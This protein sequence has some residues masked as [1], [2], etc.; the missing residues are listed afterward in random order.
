M[1]PYRGEKN[2]ENVLDEFQG[3]GKYSH[4]VKTLTGADKGSRKNNFP[5]L[6]AE[7]PVWQ[8]ARTA[9]TPL[10]GK[11]EQRRQTGWIDTQTGEVILART[12][13]LFRFD[14]NQKSNGFTNVIGSSQEG[15]DVSNFKHRLT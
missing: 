9:H 12:Q 7:T 14:I 1:L 13:R 2:E 3:K 5:G 4:R 8:G 6:G 15:Q 11:D 10:Y